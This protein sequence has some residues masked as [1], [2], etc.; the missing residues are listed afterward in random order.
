MIKKVLLFS[1][2]FFFTISS[3]AQVE[4]FKQ[5]F[6]ESTVRA[7]YTSDNPSSSQFT[8]ISNSSSVL[9][10][11]TN[12][13]LRFTKTGSSSAYFYRNINTDLTQEPTLMKM[14]FDFAVAGQNEDHPD[15]RRA[16]S[17]Y[18]GPSFARVGTSIADVH[19]RFGLGISETT[20]SFFLQVLDNGSAKSVDFSGKQTITFMVNNSGSTQTYLAPD[21]S[22]ESIAD[23]TWEIWVGTTKVFND[24]ASRNKDLSLGSFKLQYNSFLPKGILDFDNFEFI[25]LLNQEIVKT[26]SLEHPHILV[27]NADKQKILD[28]IAYYDWASSMFNQ[29]MERQSL[30]EEIHVSDPKFILKS[31]PGIPG[32]RSTHRTILNRAVECGIIYY[33]TGNEGYAQ[34]SADILHH[35]VKMISV[36]D[37][38]NFKFYSSSF[39]HLIQTREH[40]PRVGI[41]YDFIHSFISKETTTV[42]DYETETRIPFNFD[43]SQKA[44]EVMAENVLKVGGTNSNHPVLEL[45]G[46]LYNVMCMEDDATR[47]RYFQRLWNG[48]S[49]QNGIT[50]MLNHFTKEESMWPEAVG[51]SK[52]THAIVLKVMNV[53]DRYKP[54]LKIIENNLN[55]LDGIFI[56]DNFYYPNGSTIA[57]GDIGRTFTGDNHVYRNVLAMGDRLGLAAYKE[58]AAITLKK[59]YN[60]EGGYKPVI[61]TQSL[62]W[63][64]PLQ[65]LWGVNIDDAVVSTGTPLYN[66]VTA[67]Y[68]GMV[69]QRNFVEEN[70]VD[71]GLMYYTGGGS[72]VHAHA[73]GLDMELYG[74]GYIMGPDYGNDDYGSD[75]HETYAVS[76][77]AHNTVIVNGAT[78]RGVSSSG[79]W[80]NIV[81]PI[82]LEASEPEA[83]A[84]PISDNFGFSTQFLEDRNNNLDQQRTNSIVRTSATTGYY[85]DVF[86]SISKDVNNYH[87]YLFHGLGDVMQMKTGEIALNLT[88]TPERYNNDLGDSRKQPGWRWYTDAKTSQLTADAISARFDLQFDNKYLHVNV[89]GGIEKEY[90]SALAP[91]TKYVRNG[92]SNKKTQMFMMRKYGEAW[93]KPFVTIYEPSS[94]A[95][96]SVKST[97]NII[98]NNKVV[99]VKVISEVNGQKI[100]DFI[101]TNDSEEAI[102]LSDLNIAFT[103]RFGIV[104]TIEK[105]TNTDVSLYIGK[106]SQLT[107]L[108]ETIT[109]DASGKAFLEYTLDYTLST[110]DFNNL[111][112]RVTVFPNPSE[113]LFEINLPLNVKN[114]K[115]QVYNIQGQLVV[116]KKQP[117]NGGNAKLDIRNQAKGIYFVKV[118]LET[119]VFIKVIKK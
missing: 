86:R 66:T 23:D 64:N 85:V 93:N 28:N 45:T 117:V 88:A 116:S 100:T 20:G 46:A 82:V 41:A 57:Y 56:F 3:S 113:G 34:L 51:Y 92:Y 102:Q 75:I 2:I 32:D 9:S 69:M 107:F 4:I 106:G 31:I 63:N 24:I 83:Y 79:T 72:Y 87:D 105:A 97:S 48:D 115:L 78:K 19:S 40:F 62:E 74:A 22:T 89:P 38:L 84:N 16:M 36:Q 77:A 7:D 14:K 10:S 81:D 65:L 67:K 8:K 33:L 5:D 91:A 47:E 44:F 98:N 18:F 11:I 35:Y 95:I 96:S 15:D 42:F 111:E 6:N 68:A 29:L 26:Q 17:F 59:R 21:N 53:L 25:D 43:T 52:F 58:K 39:N 94:S 103:G 119:P 80:L 61:E 13:A 50:W 70:N 1:V 104:R 118:N 71:N 110:L 99:G 90:S 73:T 112:K 55:L 109:G 12:G 108:D 37:P 27:S 60:D 49:N 54:E 101:L 30:Y 114:I 76:H